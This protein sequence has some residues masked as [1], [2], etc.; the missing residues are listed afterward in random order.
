M[1]TYSN[2]VYGFTRPPELDGVRARRPIA[3]VGAGPVGLV[4]AIDLAQRGQPVLVLDEP[5]EGLAPIIVQELMRAIRNL[6][7]EGGL[8]LILVEQHAKLALE[9]TRRVLVLDRGRVVHRGSSA[10]LRGDPETL[11]RLVAVA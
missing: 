5:M 7:D 1:K 10:E 3:I 11:H 2:P 4:A 8:T 6:V 9:L